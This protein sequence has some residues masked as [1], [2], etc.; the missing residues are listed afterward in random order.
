VLAAMPYSICCFA[1]LISLLCPSAWAHKPIV[2]DGGPTTPDTAYEI[3]DVDV[4]QVAYH[5]ATPTQPRL[6]LG[7][8]IPAGQKLFLQLGAPKLSDTNTIRPAMA[9]LGPGLPDIDLPFEIPEGYGGYLYDTEGQNGEF[10]HEEFTG[11]DSW[12]FPAQEPVVPN[13]G[14]YYLVGYLPDTPQGKF[15]MAIGTAEKFG[16]SDILSLPGVVFKVRAFHEVGP[17]GGLIFW[18]MLFIAALAVTGFTILFH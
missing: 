17:F 16:L 15:W 9:L 4:S 7:F 18:A 10:F 11:T 6:W 3:S 1:V 14:L 2:V 13:A 5:E 8:Q 12:L